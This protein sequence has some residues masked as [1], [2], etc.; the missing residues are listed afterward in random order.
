MIKNA[1]YKFGILQV[2]RDLELLLLI[3]ISKNSLI[4]RGANGIMLVFD[5][6]NE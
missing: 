1:N 3:T 4:F 6:T 5:V 2:S